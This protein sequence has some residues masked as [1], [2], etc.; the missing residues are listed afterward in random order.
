M[1]AM[2]VAVTFAEVCADNTAFLAQ[3]QASFCAATCML[4]AA[5]LVAWVL[6]CIAMLAEFAAA[7]ATICLHLVFT[8]AKDTPIEVME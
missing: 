3:M 5:R 6:A 4:N 7:L 2:R 1:A 8:V